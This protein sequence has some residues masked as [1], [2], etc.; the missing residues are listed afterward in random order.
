[1]SRFS[2]GLALAV[3][4]ALPHLARAE[5]ETLSASALFEVYERNEIVAEDTY[6]GRRIGISG[7]ISA[8]K[9]AM[10][11]APILLLE[12]GSPNKLVSCHFP[13][14]AQAELAALKT[15]DQVS[16]NCRIKYRMGQTIHASACSLE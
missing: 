10:M 3:A 15:G 9:K 6:N 14:K 8:I 4:L 13:Q 11:G 5:A 1:M 7:R 12:A 2:T 16:V